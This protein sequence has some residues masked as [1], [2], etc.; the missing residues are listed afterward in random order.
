MS[1]KMKVWAFAALG[2]LAL[3]LSASSLQAAPETVTVKGS[4]IDLSC[5]TKGMAMM[6]SDHNALSNDHKTPKGVMNSCAAMCLKGG[7]PAALWSDGKISAVFLANPTFTLHKYAHKNVE[8]QGFWG[9]SKDVKTFF[10][11]K[12]REAGSKEWVDV[13]TSAMH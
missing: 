4:V 8:V 10:P 6:G 2:A 12:I 13:Q 3:T 5:A 9:G 1:V 7:Q 11:Q